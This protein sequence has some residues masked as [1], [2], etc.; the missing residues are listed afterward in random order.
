MW[1]SAP[2]I[3]NKIINNF[4]LQ[5][6]F[7]LAGNI[8][9]S[10]RCPL[11]LPAEINH[12][13]AKLLVWYPFPGETVIVQCPLYLS[14]QRSLWYTLMHMRKRA[15]IHIRVYQPMRSL[16]W[17]SNNHLDDLARHLYSLYN[18]SRGMHWG[19]TSAL[20]CLGA[21]PAASAGPVSQSPISPACIV[22][23][24]LL[25]L[26]QLASVDNYHCYNKHLVTFWNKYSTFLIL[27]SD[28]L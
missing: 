9:G 20:A 12:Y 17:L 10:T 6:S 28:F 5:R 13:S 25:H 7:H 3:A 18:R 27:C 4:R 11:R 1:N 15:L 23:D 22:Y 21:G 8:E 2:K 19:L 16:G 26:Y 24:I 14:H